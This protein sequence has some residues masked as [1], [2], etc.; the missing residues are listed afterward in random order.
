M[1]KLGCRKGWFLEDENFANRNEGWDAGRVERRVGERQVDGQIESLTDRQTDRQKDRQKERQ[2]ERKKDR[3][4]NIN[5]GRQT[6]SQTN[7]RNLAKSFILHKKSPLGGDAKKNEN[8][9]TANR[10]ASE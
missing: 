10:S 9:M 6:D 2:T 7:R 8:K 3:E 1:L 4:V 5:I